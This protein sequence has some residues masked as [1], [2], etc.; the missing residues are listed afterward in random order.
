MADKKSI[1]ARIMKCGKTRIWIDPERLGD[2]TNAITAADL[3]RLIK[4]GVVRIKPASRNSRGRIK[5]KLAQKKKGKR[6]GP[7]SRKGKSTARTNEK[8]EWMVKVRKL[9]SYLRELR[10]KGMLK[11]GTYRSI[12]RKIGSGMFRGVTHMKFYLKDHDL[13]K[14]NEN[15]M[16]KK[17]EQ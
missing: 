3:R 15:E 10:K 13:L 5:K 11:D 8:K 14:V 2:I 9:R 17:D 6:K 7:G 12:Y 1:I 4:D 16:E